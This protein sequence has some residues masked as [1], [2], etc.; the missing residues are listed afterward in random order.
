[1]NEKKQF[2]KNFLEIY[3]QEITPCL[4]SIDI[5]LKTN[6]NIDIDTASRLLS[7]SDLEINNIMS[8]NNIKIITPKD[9]I[10]IMLNGSSNIC[11]L[12][13]RQ[14]IC[15]VHTYYLPKEIS[16][17]Y[18]LDLTAIENSCKFLNIK[19]ITRELLPAIFAQIY[20]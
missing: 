14:C 12:F 16:Y 17:I 19:Y 6:E 10:I 15:G 11:T 20:F 13:K 7:I 9:F 8:F 2:P 1:M 5:L 3:E 18:S 4:Q